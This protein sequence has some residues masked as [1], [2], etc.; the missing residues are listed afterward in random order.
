MSWHSASNRHWGRD[1]SWILEHCPAN[2]EW[3]K[4]FATEVEAVAELR[5]H[6]CQECLDGRL[7][8]VDSSAEGGIAYEERKKPDPTSAYD[9][10]STPCGCEYELTEQQ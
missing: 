7:G 8:Y 6:I 9:L 10:L 5:K 3:S 1:V 2:E 4:T